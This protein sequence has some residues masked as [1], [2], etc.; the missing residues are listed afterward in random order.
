M[1]ENIKKKKNVFAWF[2]VIFLCIWFGGG[3]ITLSYFKENTY[4]IGERGFNTLLTCFKYGLLVSIILVVL[5]L[6]IPKKR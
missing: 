4:H 2:S 5:S 1:E 6:I 3:V